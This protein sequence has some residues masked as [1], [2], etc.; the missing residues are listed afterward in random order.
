MSTCKSGLFLCVFLLLQI[1]TILGIHKDDSK[2]LLSRLSS[3]CN[4][5]H[6]IDSLLAVAKKGHEN[7]WTMAYLILQRRT[8][9]WF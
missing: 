1:G 9:L 6:S 4:C 8:L 2:N 7:L 3:I 5:I